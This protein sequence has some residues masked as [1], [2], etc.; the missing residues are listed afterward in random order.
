MSGIKTE[1][2][3]RPARAIRWK[4]GDRRPPIPGGGRGRWAWCVWDEDGEQWAAWF[5][6][7]DLKLVKGGSN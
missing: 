6:M 3:K 1:N 7:T 5:A 2:W 4:T